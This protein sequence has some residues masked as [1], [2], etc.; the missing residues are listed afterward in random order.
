MSET[1]LINKNEYG[2]YY[3]YIG[4]GSPFGNQYVL[5]KHG[6]EYTRRESIE[7][8]RDWFNDKIDNEPEFRQAVEELRGKTLGCSCVPEACHGHVILSYLEGEP[9]TEAVD[10]YIEYGGQIE[11][12]LSGK[13]L[14]DY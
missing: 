10:K 8:Y 1:E 2:G 11:D 9:Y 14:F 6:G 12:Y 4:R 13:T 3:T 5:I 7:K